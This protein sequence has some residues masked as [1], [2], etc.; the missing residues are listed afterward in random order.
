M[1][2][3]L[4]TRAAF[5]ALLVAHIAV[6]GE[7]APG[8]GLPIVHASAN[9]VLF[10]GA[11][12]TS[13]FRI[14]AFRAGSEKASPV[15]LELPGRLLQAQNG[16][17]RTAW[18]ASVD[19]TDR[20]HLFRLLP[21]GRP[22]AAGTIS[23]RARP[24]AFSWCRDGAGAAWIVVSSLDHERRMVEPFRLEQDHWTAKGYVNAASLQ[25]PRAVPGSARSIICGAWRFSA[26]GVPRKIAASG[27]ADLAEIF[28]G[29]GRLTELRLDDL[30]VL[31]STDAGNHWREAVQPWAAGT[32]FDSPPEQ[33]D[34]NGDAPMLRWVARGR[35]YVAR[36]ESGSWSIILDAPID[37]V[38]GLSG[39]AVLV[40]DSLVFIGTCY[41]VAEGEPDSFRIGLIRHGRVQTKTIVVSNPI[42]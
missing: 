35:V 40:N 28:P 15:A 2:L 26:Q 34:R 18:L 7:H 37:D 23:P 5:A 20:I 13:P 22:I 8:C 11:L 42:R 38:R 33:I 25:T 36:F 24:A 30:V 4:V 1:R 21:E 12:E 39:P 17:G 9:G 16:T 3:E 27:S 14:V 32:R 10:I 31:T 41:R 29:R 6:A 19:D